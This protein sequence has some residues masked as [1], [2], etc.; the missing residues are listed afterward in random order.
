MKLLTGNSNRPLADAIGKYLDLPFTRAVVRR[1]ADME[2]HTENSD[3]EGVWITYQ[4]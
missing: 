1:F 2:V 3:T 4:K